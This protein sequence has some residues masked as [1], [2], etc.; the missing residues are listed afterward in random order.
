MFHAK[1]FPRLTEMCRIEPYL[2]KKSDSLQKG[3]YRQVSVLTVISKLY[4]SVMIDQMTDIS[5]KF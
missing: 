1:H 3:N 2:Q 5:L 4:E